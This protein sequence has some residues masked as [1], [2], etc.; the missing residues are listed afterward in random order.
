MNKAEELR[1]ESFLRVESYYET[2][3][4][5]L[6]PFGILFFVG[7]G[8]VILYLGILTPNK[9]VPIVARGFLSLLGVGF[10]YLAYVGVRL[11]PFRSARVVADHAGLR[12]TTRSLD[13]FYPWSELSRANDNSTLQILDVYSSRGHRVLSVDY[14]IT[15][16]PQLRER[17]FQ[18]LNR[19]V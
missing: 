15:E 10:L 9:T 18:N 7:L 19:N 2:A 8:C 3:V 11:L 6:I 4:R 5:W 13:Q 1:T 16:F 14:F 17:I 12:V